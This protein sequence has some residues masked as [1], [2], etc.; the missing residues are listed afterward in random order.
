MFCGVICLPLRAGIIKHNP[1]LPVDSPRMAELFY[2]FLTRYEE[3]QRAKEKE[4]LSFVA[5]VSL[6]V[7]VLFFPW[8]SN[9]SGLAVC[10]LCL[11]LFYLAIRKYLYYD[12]LV[13]HLYVNVHILHHHLLGK[14]D[15][16]FCS[17]SEPCNCAETFRRYVWKNY[18]ISL[19]GGPLD[20]S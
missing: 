2:E 18:R 13:N 15:V 12:E 8:L 11:M 19:Y 16:G 20:V 10:G 17:H 4:V 7:G 14:M 3:L 5:G 1:G 9:S 6:G